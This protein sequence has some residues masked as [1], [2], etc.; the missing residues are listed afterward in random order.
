M[1]NLDLTRFKRESVA[2]LRKEEAYYKGV[3][4]IITFLIPRRPLYTRT[5]SSIY[6]SYSRYEPS[7]LRNP[8]PSPGS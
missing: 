1:L 3:S 6:S 4:K 8:F 5:A 7:T 2:C